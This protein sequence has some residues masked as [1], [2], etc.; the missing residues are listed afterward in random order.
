MATNWLPISVHGPHPPHMVPGGTDSD[1]CQIFVGRAHHAGDLLP[2]KVI[3]D[4]NA[5]YVPYGGEETFVDQVEVLVHKQLVW[6]VAS[7]GQVPLGAIIGGHTAD[8]EPLYIGR[9]YHEG[10]HTVGK[11]QCSHN[12]IYIPYGAGCWQ[13]CNINGPFPHNMVRAGI[14]TD[15]DVIYVGRAFH[16]GDMIPAKV[17]PTKNLAYICY[18]GE[19]ILKEDFEVLRYGA[20]VWEFA[21][22]GSVPDTA[23]KIGMT[24]DGEPLYMG[25]AI[26]NGSQ[27]PG[28][29]QPSHGC[30]Y[31]PFDGE[32]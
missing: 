24:A 15:G 9:T 1:G 30:C 32:E 20:F 18:G 19:E 22:A 2:A 8:G 12:C 28:K 21:T 25:R 5:A 13:Y 10:S 6:D 11:V 31:I 23:V 26:H 27:T 3:P 29:V 16:E 17:I 4:K 14:D 7:S